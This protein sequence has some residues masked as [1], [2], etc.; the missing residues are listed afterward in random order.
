MR[1]QG[2]AIVGGRAA[3][4]A[5]LRGVG[6]AVSPKRRSAASAPS[7]GIIVA[8]TL[9]EPPHVADPDPLGSASG[10]VVEEEAA[11]P[12]A[13]SFPVPVVGGLDMD[14]FRAGEI[15]HVDGNNG[16]VEVE[17]L[18]ETGVVT[19]F[20]QNSQG[21]ILLL[22]RSPRVGSFQGRWA[23]VSEFLESIPPFQQAIKEI[24]EETG[25]PPR[26][27]RLRSSRGRP[28]YARDGSRVF[29]VHPFLFRVRNPEVRLD[30]EHTESRW[31][32]PSELRE[33]ETVPKLEQVWAV[34]QPGRS[35]DVA[36][37]G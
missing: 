6:T 14:L 8:R 28:V 10:W 36:K 27:L 31:V 2:L 35:I 24:G 33:Y 23:A 25:I 37:N 18:M 16:G 1:F 34:L 26:A 22:R 13:G 12:A 32:D 15:L 5:W 11:L 9:P 17:G 21:Q 29:A 30:W 4:P 20:V 19:S 7:G 3:G